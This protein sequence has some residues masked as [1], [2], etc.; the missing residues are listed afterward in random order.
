[1]VAHAAAAIAISDP[2]RQARKQL[3][4]FARLRGEV[5]TVVFFEFAVAIGNVPQ[6]LL[7]GAIVAGHIQP[8]LLDVVG[9]VEQIRDLRVARGERLRVLFQGRQGLGAALPAASCP[10][11]HR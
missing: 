11:T 9:C 3:L 5:A 7:R 10:G 4:Q 6:P 2:S 8:G 1:V